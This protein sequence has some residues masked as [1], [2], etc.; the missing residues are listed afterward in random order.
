MSFKNINTVVQFFARCAK[1]LPC[2]QNFIYGHPGRELAARRSKINYPYLHLENLDIKYR[3]GVKIYSGAFLVLFC[4]P[5]DDYQK[6]DDALTQSDII[7]DEIISFLTHGAG[8]D[9]D[10]QNWWCPFFKIEG[11]NPFCG[12]VWGY[13]VPFEVT[14]PLPGCGDQICW[15]P[16]PC[17][18][19]VPGFSY[20]YTTAEGLIITDDSEGAEAVTYTATF[21][22]AGPVALDL[23][24]P[25]LPA[26]FI[27]PNTNC[28]RCVVIIQKVE[29][30][31]DDGKI[32][33]RYARAKIWP[34]NCGGT[35]GPWCPAF[36]DP[37]SFV[38]NPG[39]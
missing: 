37:Q 35:A 23:G 6:Q 7:T 11:K 38:L 18:D 10:H 2:L 25:I 12:D 15:T 21:D 39:G 24:T 29:A 16:D 13:H 19:L 27:D 30:T 26:D 32:C 33:T 1:M 4:P 3:K 22:G 17:P 28:Q 5:R 14:G 20:T 31:G 8:H 9:E 36:C 34:C